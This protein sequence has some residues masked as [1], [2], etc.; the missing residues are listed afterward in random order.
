MTSPAAPMQRLFAFDARFV[1]L[2]SF[3]VL[4]NQIEV[5]REKVFT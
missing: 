5:S 3:F 1:L 2:A 4:N